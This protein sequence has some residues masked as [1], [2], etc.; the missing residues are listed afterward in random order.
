MLTQ[1]ARISELSYYKTNRKAPKE[2]PMTH[3]FIP[4]DGGCRDL[5]SCR[6]AVIVY[7]ATATFCERFLHPRDRSVAQ[8]VQAARSG[9]QSIVEH[10]GLRQPMTRVRITERNRQ[11]ESGPRPSGPGKEIR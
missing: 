2:L 10:G 11:K 4:A 3:R 8:M 1:K 5:L 6:K 9:K 7:D